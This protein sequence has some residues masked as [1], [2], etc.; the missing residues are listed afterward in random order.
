MLYLP[1]QGVMDNIRDAYDFSV[2]ELDPYNTGFG[3]ERISG[4]GIFHVDH[5]FTEAVYVGSGNNTGII[6]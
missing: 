2:N 1:K 4:K 5:K 3:L 6:I